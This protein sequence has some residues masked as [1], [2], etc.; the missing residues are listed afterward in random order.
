MKSSESMAVAWWIWQW[1][2]QHLS[3][4]G[5]RWVWFTDCLVYEEKIT[6]RDIAARPLCTCNLSDTFSHSMLTLYHA[7]LNLEL[8]FSA[9][10]CYAFVW[11]FHSSISLSIPNL[12]TGSAFI[13]KNDFDHAL[14][15]WPT[16][17]S[18]RPPT[19]ATGGEQF[20]W[21]L[22]FGAVFSCYWERYP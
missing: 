22:L 17:G 10:L 9:T 8:V 7:R 1:Q 3:N 12:K 13:S 19:S 4:D 18:W 14:C 15:M 21:A 11:Y 2:K 6:G 20:C 16:N 5:R